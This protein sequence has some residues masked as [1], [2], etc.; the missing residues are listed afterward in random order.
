MKNNINYYIQAVNTA[1][2]DT[3]DNGEL[4]NEHFEVLRAALDNDTVSDIPV[5][6]LATIKEKFEAGTEKYR[7]I[8]AVL[9]GLKPPVKVLG[10]HKQLLK[11]YQEFVQ[12][13]QEMTNSIDVSNQS[14]D[15]EAFERSEKLQD[16]S[17]DNMM[18][19]IQRITK[20]LF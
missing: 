2:T 18:K 1:I 15:V 6:Q 7:G 5:K 20:I 14:I 16:E 9:N 19:N 8:D 11:A 17:S 10:V 12:G 3:E 13:C 4:L